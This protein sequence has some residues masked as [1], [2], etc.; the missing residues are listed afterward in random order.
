MTSSFTNIRDLI[1]DRARKL[2]SGHVLESAFVVEVSRKVLCSFFKMDPSTT[3]FSSILYF[4]GKLSV[5]V[6]SA[7]FANELKNCEV[8]ILEHLRKALPKA[9][10]STLFIKIG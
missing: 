2:P 4:K 1:L 7:S 6:T 5:T 10:F 8:Q 9:D 3:D